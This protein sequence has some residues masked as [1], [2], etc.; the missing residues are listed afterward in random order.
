MSSDEP[1]LTIVVVTYNQAEHW[2]PCFLHSCA[3]QTRKDFRVEVW[4]D[5]MDGWS[6][7]NTADLVNKFHDDYT[8]PVYMRG[9]IERTNDFGHSMRASALT[10]CGTKYI[11]WQNGDNYLTPRFVELFLNAAESSNL[12][13]VYSNLLHN[14][15]NVNGDGQGPYNV[16]ISHPHLNRID[17]AN[18]VVKTE[19]AQKVGFNHRDSGADGKF[20]NELMAHK[21]QLRIGKMNC[22]P[23]VHN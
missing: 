17:I 7:R 4:H 16:L 14:Y 21:D 6:Y 3:L 10:Q 2:L 15:A 12:D 23:V 5:G 11:N 20:V 13:F 9:S 22:V 18:F 19:W 8:F 1:L